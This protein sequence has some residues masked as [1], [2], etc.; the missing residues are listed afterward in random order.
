[1]NCSVKR[2][3][4]EIL[5]EREEEHSRFTELYRSAG[6]E[7]GD[8]WTEINNPIVSFAARRNGLL[9]GAATVSNRFGRQ[10][11][12]YL[13]VIPESRGTG[14]GRRL[15]EL[16]IDFAQ[17]RGE[18]SLWVAAKKP[19]YYRRLGAHE[20]E[21]TVLLSDCRRCPDY[22]RSCDPKELVFHLKETP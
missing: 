19:A 11:L 3:M 18:T 10:V 22:R 16:C 13:A 1:M 8:N 21:D 2:F 4:D 20:T 12:D 9:L 14:I 15:T 7:V 6:L 17:S 5:Y